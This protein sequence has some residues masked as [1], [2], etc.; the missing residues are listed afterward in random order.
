MVELTKKKLRVIP[1]I[2]NAVP[3]VLTD[4]QSAGLEKGIVAAGGCY[5]VISVWGDIIVD[6]HNRYKV[7]QKHDL[8]FIMVDVTKIIGDSIAGAIHYARELQVNRRQS[9]HHEESN[10]RVAIHEHLISLGKSHGK[11][12]REV[13]EATGVSTRQLYRDIEYVE[14]QKKLIPELKATTAV[15]VELSKEQ[16]KALAKMT[17]AQQKDLVDRSGHEAEALKENIKLAV[18]ERKKEVFPTRSEEE[19]AKAT[20][21]TKHDVK[22]AKAPPV[23]G[24]VT[25]MQSLLV[26]MNK[27]V[28]NYRKVA[29]QRREV[30]S[31]IYN[32]TQ[33]DSMFSKWRSD[34]E[35]A[36]FL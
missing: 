9:N 10:I 15:G 7:C 26:D 23:L 29:G 1:E 2:A 32:M 36:D 24:M 28:N 3:G 4:E 19:E 16:V 22:R 33:L 27:L 35:A 25:Q 21:P 6:G 31:V 12:V 5:S 30:E 11:A 18:K 8:P 17:P 13:A 20:T 14:G 34:A